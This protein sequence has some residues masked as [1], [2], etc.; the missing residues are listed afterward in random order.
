MPTAITV[1][2]DRG[3]VRHVELQVPKDSSTPGATVSATA[4][5]PSL[6]GSRFRVTIDRVR[7]VLDA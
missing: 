1:S 5:F 2:N 3:Q 4:R 6:T 7:P